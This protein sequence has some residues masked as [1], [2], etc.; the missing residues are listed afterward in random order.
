MEEPAG[1]R[2]FPDDFIFGAATASYQIEGATGEDGRG[3]S[4]W[5][6]FCRR[7]GRVAG[8]DNGDIACDHYHRYREDIAIMSELGVEAYRF[9]IAWPRIVPD[10]E[11]AVN[12]AGLDFY[13]RLVD[14]LLARGIRPFVTLFH[15]DLPLALQRRYGGFADRRCIDAYVRYVETVVSA[16][17]DRVR[18]WVTFNEPWVYSVLG[19]LLGIH[20]PGVRNPWKA[21]RVAHH[22]LVAHGRAVTRIREISPDARVGITLNLTPVHPVERRSGS[23]KGAGAGMSPG[24]GAT[25]RDRAAAEM[26]DQSLNRFY[27][28]AVFTGTYPE[29]FRRRLGILRPPVMP[30]DMETIAVPID[31][32]GVN[33]YT[34]HR[35]RF[36]WKNP[37]FFFDMDGAA[38]PERE[39]VGPKGEQYTAMGW[40]V[41]PQGLRE[42]LIRLKEEYN[43]PPVYITENGAAFTDELEPEPA[44]AARS[45]SRVVRDPL[46]IAYLEQY[47]AAVHQAL[48]EG[49]DVRGYFVWSLLDNFEWAHGYSRRFGIVH[50]DYRTQERTVKESGRWYAA[51]MAA[52]KHQREHQPEHEPQRESAKSGRLGS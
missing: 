52:R 26:A 25:A 12:G 10:G 1:Y 21:F 20:A 11:G 33:N 24:A 39:F 35:A 29:R 43:N 37:P 6:E 18:D 7:P 50:V 15:W 5:D 22:Q 23:G 4:I 3:E 17:G 47:T 48:Q 2:R 40:E 38:V 14:S 16:L 36:S 45:T 46:R 27:L 32:L 9:S 41:Y 49:C 34:R 28:D 51:L 13:S 30:G 44:Q 19:H 42:I 8:G 31:F